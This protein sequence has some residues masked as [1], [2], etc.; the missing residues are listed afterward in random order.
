MTEDDLAK[1]SDQIFAVQ[2]LL[3]AHILATEQLLEGSAQA[4]VE[5]VRSEREAAVRNG[6][7]RVAV[8]LNALID[9][10]DQSL[11]F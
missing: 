9:E 6:R 11:D 3:L 5:I 2:C 8:R 4:T 10:I 7:G 1:L